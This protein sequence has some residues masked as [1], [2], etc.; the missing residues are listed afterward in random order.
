MK[1]TPV[2]QARYCRRTNSLGKANTCL[3]ANTELKMHHQASLNRLRQLLLIQH[4][5]HLLS[6]FAFISSLDLFS[7]ENSCSCEY[8]RISFTLLFLLLLYDPFFCELLFRES[9][10]V[11][12]RLHILQTR[13]NMMIIHVAAVVICGYAEGKKQ[14][15]NVS[16]A[17]FREFH[18]Q[19]RQTIALQTART[20]PS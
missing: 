15:E 18:E 2:L 3:V 4:N 12:S 7:K 10:Q 6:I 16:L 8:F 9:T 5:S 20:V 19:C 11:L 13:H 14:H 17:G 1:K